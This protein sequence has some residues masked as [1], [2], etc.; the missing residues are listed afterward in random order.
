MARSM[1]LESIPE[2]LDVRVGEAS[3]EL[4]LPNR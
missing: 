4:Q 1:S 3:G 2:V